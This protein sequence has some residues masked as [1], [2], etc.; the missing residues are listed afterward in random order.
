MGLLNAAKIGIVIL[1]ERQ[2][3]KVTPPKLTL[4][5]ME[6]AHINARVSRLN[7]KE[8][9]RNQVASLTKVNQLQMVNTKLNAIQAAKKQSPAQLKI[10]VPQ[11]GFSR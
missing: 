8:Q 10:Q 1:N 5:Q 4:A 2:K 6:K 9:M 3:M 11:R 7:A